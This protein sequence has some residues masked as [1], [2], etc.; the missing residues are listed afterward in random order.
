VIDTEPGS[1]AVIERG[2]TV[3]LRV[4]RGVEQVEVPDVV[5]ESEDNARSA[6][7]GAGLRGGE[8]TERESADEEP[9]TV[10]EQDPAAGERLD[11][12]SAVDLVVAAAP[13]EV[14]VPDVVGMTEDEARTALE[15]AGFAARVRDQT[16]TDP[17][18]DG[19]V[20]DQ[21]PDPGEQRPEGSTIRIAVGR[22]GEATPTPSPTVGVPNGTSLH[23]DRPV[24]RDAQVVS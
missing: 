4:S 12:G 17:A 18:Q 10:L 1:G 23:R 22:L 11:R 5:G 15:D 6:L 20:Q 8:V 2:S 14:A 24:G 19:V 7:E 3:V 21:A 16:V 9:G 13:P